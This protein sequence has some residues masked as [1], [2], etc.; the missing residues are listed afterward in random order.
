MTVP[1]LGRRLLTIV[2]VCTVGHA[3]PEKCVRAQIFSDD[4]DDLA[5]VSRYT[6]PF[7]SLEQAPLDG[8]VD[9]AFDYGVNFGL[10]SAP[11]STGG[12]TVGIGVSLNP[13][14]D[15]AIDEGEG[16][17]VSPLIDGLPNDYTMTIDAIAMYL[18]GGGA[19]EHIVVGIN[20]DRTATPYIFSPAGPGQFFSVPHDSGLDNPGFV[21]DYY[22]IADGAITE[23]YDGD[24]E[25]GDPAPDASTVGVFPEGTDPLF[26]DPGF[27]G[28]QWMTITLTK[29]GNILKFYINDFLIDTFDASGG[30]TSG[31]IV[32]GGADLFNSSNLTNMVVFDNLVVTEGVHPPAPPV[33][34]DADFDG[35]AIVDGEDFMLWQRGLGAN[36]GSAAPMD[37][38]ANGDLFV[39]DLDLAVW[40]EQYGT[41]APA[42][43]TTA[44]EPATIGLAALALAGRRRR[45]RL[46]G[47]RFA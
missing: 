31:H 26:N 27:P 1:R 15:G 5:A 9:Y 36:P 25:D 8:F 7:F 33:G 14:D 21:D 23:L 20:A 35:N 30:T 17:G 3:L 4:F 18:I 43:A 44:P 28:N 41:G 38:D 13:D 42:A 19:S 29:G 16:I 24:D 12:T 39:N 6:Q 47:R 46:R 11:N 22:R 34:D 2:L 45:R 32:L 10:G 40:S 37:G